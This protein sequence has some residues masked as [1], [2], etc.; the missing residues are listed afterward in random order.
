MSYPWN[1]APWPAE[2]EEWQK[3]VTIRAWL[4]RP[5]S[6]A[7]IG[8]LWTAD[9]TM[10][11][12][13]IFSVMADWSTD[14]ELSGYGVT[15]R[16]EADPTIGRHVPALGEMLTRAEAPRAE[17]EWVEVR[18]EL[19]FFL[20]WGLVQALRAHQR[21]IFANAHHAEP[22]GSNFRGMSFY[23]DSIDPDKKGGLTF[24]WMIQAD[25]EPDADPVLDTE[26]GIKATA[27]IILDDDDP[28]SDA[29][30]D[31]AARRAFWRA[32]EAAGFLIHSASRKAIRA[33]HAGHAEHATDTTAGASHD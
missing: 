7:E 33:E 23:R 19:R 27:T 21:D 9:S 10:V 26:V 32:R 17:I 30:L 16:N 20:S 6:A 8:R 3:D 22:E 13:G 12:D 2:P 1:D 18:L 29:S 25:Q 15:T 31:L 5:L 4:S 14:K 28:R 11:A 24:G